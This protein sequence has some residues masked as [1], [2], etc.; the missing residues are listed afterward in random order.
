MQMKSI[1]ANAVGRIICYMTGVFHYKILTK[2][3]DFVIYL[4][5]LYHLASTNCI[6]SAGQGA[7]IPRVQ[8]FRLVESRL[9]QCFLTEMI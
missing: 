3:L 8:W 2:L 6:M 1:L 4:K 5:Q 9:N 7:I